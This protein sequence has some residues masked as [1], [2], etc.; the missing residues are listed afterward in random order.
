M[1]YKV[2]FLQFALLN[3]DTMEKAKKA[4]EKIEEK[5]EEKK[6]GKGNPWK[7]KKGQAQ[8]EGFNVP[9]YLAFLILILGM[10]IGMAGYSVLFPCQP[11]YIDDCNDQGNG[12]GDLTQ[13]VEIKVLTSDIFQDIDGEQ[14]TVFILLDQKGVKYD[15]KTF[16]VDN[17]EGENLQ[18]NFDVKLLPTVLINADDLKSYASGHQDLL[19]MI[20]AF[21]NSYE[22]VN[23]YYVVPEDN[24]DLKAHAKV[25]LET[26]IEGCQARVEGISSVHLFQDPY[27][28][29][30]L[31]ST[32]FLRD[33]RANYEGSADYTFVYNL[34]Q[35]SQDNFDVNEMAQA[36]LAAKYLH[37]AQAQGKFFE[38]HSCFVDAYC[39]KNDSG[40]AEDGEIM[41]CFKGNSHYTNPLTT[42][43]LDACVVATGLNQSQADSFLENE[44]GLKLESDLALSSAF[45]VNDLDVVM[46]TV[47]CTI[48]DVVFH[49]DDILCK[50]RPDIPICVEYASR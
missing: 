37:A 2:F 10:V 42:E 46:A 6:E 40:T 27:T 18:R 32:I 15:R 35:F 1:I 4:E 29:N 13:E 22:T 3:G 11:I 48:N 17:P 7:E 36:E 25:W 33:L 49:V 21:D 8:P 14:N 20:Q 16:N 50:I 28:L 44:A 12:N 45:K 26:P 30:S 31:N 5:V 24:L 9:G 38:F 39:D 47:E 23:G 34:S 41:E 19:L 43:E